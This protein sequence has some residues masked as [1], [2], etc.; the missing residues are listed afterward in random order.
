MPVIIKKIIEVYVEK[1]NE[2]E[3]F[4]DCV[5]RLGI[6]PFKKKIYVQENIKI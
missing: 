3:L 2:E 4:I 5:E 6:D 1:R